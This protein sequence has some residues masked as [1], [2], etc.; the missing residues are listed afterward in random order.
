MNRGFF[1]FHLI[2]FGFDMF[3]GGTAHYVHYVC[4]WRELDVFDVG[5]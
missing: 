5:H 1:F 3:V 4:G 2:G